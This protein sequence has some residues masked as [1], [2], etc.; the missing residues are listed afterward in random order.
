MWLS[1]GA[2]CEVIMCV[3]VSH[4]KWNYEFKYSCV[5]F[6][7]FMF[8]LFICVCMLCCFCYGHDD[9]DDNDKKDHQCCSNS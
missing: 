3:C 5:Y 9:D 2:M 7:C 8:I 1:D 6:V 4:I